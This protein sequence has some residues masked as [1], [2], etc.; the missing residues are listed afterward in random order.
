MSCEKYE[1]ASWKSCPPFVILAINVVSMEQSSVE[2]MLSERARDY[3][4]SPWTFQSYFSG[5]RV[6]AANEYVLEQL[7]IE[8]NI[9]VENACNRQL[10]TLSV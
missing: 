9:D 8:T 1:S 6:D 4:E 7:F 5:L 2:L 10:P 3:H